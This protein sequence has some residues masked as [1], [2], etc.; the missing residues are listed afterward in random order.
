MEILENYL[1]N[2]RSSGQE[3]LGASQSAGLSLF[4]Q[5]LPSYHRQPMKLRTHWG[6]LD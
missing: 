1:V 4:K 6:S 3:F 2:K 5:Q